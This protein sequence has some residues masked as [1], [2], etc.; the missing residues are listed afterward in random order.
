M[1]I[2]FVCTGNTCRSPMAA[3][4]LREM[5]AE[6]SIKD[7]N[8]ASAGIAA[9][10]GDKASPNAVK[11]VSELG[12]DLDGHRSKQIDEELLKTSDLILTMTESHKLAVKSWEPS[13]WDKTYTLKEY[14]EME[15]SDISDPFGQSEAKYR[16]TMEEIRQSLDK[17]IEK[18][19]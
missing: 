13:V 15:D 8:V 6:R 2:L 16:Q 19:I 5:L 18:L 9:M 10:P 14:A 7:I 17:I 11:A 3:A 1:N 12:V 4:L